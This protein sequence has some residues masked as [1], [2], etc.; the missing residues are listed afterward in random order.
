MPTPQS[1]SPILSIIRQYD[2][3]NRSLKLCKIAHKSHNILCCARQAQISTCCTYL[4][5]T[6]TVPDLLSDFISHSRLIAS[7]I[8]GHT[9]GYSRTIP[10]K[11]DSYPEAWLMVV[12]RCQSLVTAMCCCCSYQDCVR[13]GILLTEIIEMV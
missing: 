11:H 6:Y 4:G 3:L 10:E 5:F 1:P 7:T 2:R 9:S 13:A 12:G 8:Y